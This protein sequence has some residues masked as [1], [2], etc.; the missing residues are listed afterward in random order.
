MNVDTF[1]I[2]TRRY[3]VF[4]D[5][6][7]TPALMRQAVERIAPERGDRAL[8][9]VN[10][11]ADYDQAWGNQIFEQ[12]D[13]EYPATIIGHSLGPARLFERIF[14]TGSSG[15]DESTPAGTMRSGWS[16]PP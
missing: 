16:R 14:P 13:G 1:A 4:V 8:L 12:P 2:V 7:A 5:T 15:C 3:L 9:V 6:M 10:T 11:H